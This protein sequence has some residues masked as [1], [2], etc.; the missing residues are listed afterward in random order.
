M[1]VKKYSLSIR[2]GNNNYYPVEWK[3]LTDEKINDEYNLEEIDNFTTSLSE[4]E[5]KYKLIEGNYINEYEVSCP[6]IIVYFEKD[7][8]RILNEGVIFNNNKDALNKQ[9]IIDYIIENINNRQLMNKLYNAINKYNKE[10]PKLNEFLYVINKTKEIIPELIPK[11][12]IGTFSNL[13]YIDRR[14]IGVYIIKNLI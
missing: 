9:F 4:E 12:I 5:M 3:Y 10:N 1:E 14:R 2:R 6:F 8:I 13:N 7:N 11:R